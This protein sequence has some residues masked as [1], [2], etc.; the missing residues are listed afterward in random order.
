MK[1]II[2]RAKRLALQEIKKYNSPNPT[3]FELA[4][5]WGQKLA[6]KYKADKDI[7]YLGTMLMDF[8]IGESISQNRLK[9]HVKMSADAARNFLEKENMQSDSLNN[10]INCIMSHHRDIPF[11]TLEAEVCANAD[12]YRFLTPLGALSFVSQ[13]TKDRM[14]LGEA[15]DYLNS[16]L[17]EKRKI[18][19][20][21]SVKK[22]LETNYNFL[23]ELVQK[24]K[25][26]S[27]EIIEIR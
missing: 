21:A 9:D 13:L 1:K 15:I 11:A 16:K 24:S 27:A 25:T 23:K 26:N 22:E 5:K 20:L 12:C 18:A 3:H 2:E 4:N 17:D 19:S 7:V 14:G 8:K 10:V 6:E